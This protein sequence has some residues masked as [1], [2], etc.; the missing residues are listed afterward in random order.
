MLLESTSCRSQVRLRWGYQ[1]IIEQLSPLPTK[2]TKNIFTDI[3]ISDQLSR[4]TYISCPKQF[5]KCVY[6]DSHS[7]MLYQVFL[8]SRQSGNWTE[9]SFLNDF[10]FCPHLSLFCL[11]A[12]RLFEISVPLSS[13]PSSDRKWHFL[14]GTGQGSLSTGSLQTRLWWAAQSQTTCP[15]G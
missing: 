1:M 4:R 3:C 8:S 14:T 5:C 9:H 12:R 10:I 7:T 2:A 15:M 13:P 6:R 11:Q